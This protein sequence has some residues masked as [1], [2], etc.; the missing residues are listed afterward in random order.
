MIAYR[1]SWN[2]GKPRRVDLASVKRMDKLTI[3]GTFNNYDSANRR[4][5]IAPHGPDPVLLGIRG[6]SARDVL[7]AFHLLRLREPVERW[8]IFRTNHATDRHLKRAPGDTVRLNRPVKLNG[9]V[10]TKP[11]RIEGGHVFLTLGYGHKEVRCAAFEPTGQFKE[12]TARLIPGDTVTAFGGVKRPNNSELPTI[13]LEKLVIRHLANDVVF[14]NP[15]CPRCGKHMKSAGRHQGFRCTRCKLDAPK[16]TKKLIKRE[17]AVR[18]GTYLPDKK[19]HRHLTRPLSRYGI[20]NR[21][22]NRDPPTGTWHS[23]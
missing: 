13:N 21:K 8:V 22:W 2:C 3:P 14:E 23:P 1:K 9:T 6:E 10:I 5:L 15:T 7:K 16:A 20:E 17:R 11:E 19:A 18:I 4:I 12:I